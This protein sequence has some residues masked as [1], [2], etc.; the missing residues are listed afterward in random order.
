MRA[1]V[2]TFLF[3]AAGVKA[4]SDY[5]IFCPWAGAEKTGRLQELCRLQPMQGSISI[6]F[7]DIFYGERNTSCCLMRVWLPVRAWAT[8]CATVWATTLRDHLGENVGRDLAREDLTG[9][10]EH[11]DGKPNAAGADGR[12]RVSPALQREED[13][14]ANSLGLVITAAMLF[15]LFAAAML[16]GTHGTIGPM[17][18]STSTPDSKAMGNLLYGAQEAVPCPQMPFGGA[19]GTIPGAEERCL[20]RDGN[21]TGHPQH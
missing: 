4:V 10:P 20:G 2:S 3:L 6:Q 21:P 18:H 9:K 11:R 1:A 14:R 5:F 19:T 8:A 12:L 17:R 16:F 13:E 15:V 7:E